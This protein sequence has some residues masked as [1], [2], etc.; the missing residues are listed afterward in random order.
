MGSGQDC[1]EGCGHAFAIGFE[2]W[3]GVSGTVW[4]RDSADVW[5]QYLTQGLDVVCAVIEDRVMGM[6]SNGVWDTIC[7]SASLGIL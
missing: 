7:D 5:D 6:V 4:D 2:V 1:R 3:D